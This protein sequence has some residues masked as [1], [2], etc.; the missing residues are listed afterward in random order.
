MA[1]DGKSRTDRDRTPQGGR[2]RR[3]RRL[4]ASVMA[5]TAALLPLAAVAQTAAPA[6]GATGAP[7]ADAPKPGFQQIRIGY[8]VWSEKQLTLSLSQTPPD[9]LG[10]AG[11]RSGIKDNNTTGTFTKQQFSLVTREA[12]DTEAALAALKALHDEGV[13]FIVTDAPADTLLAMADS[14]AGK[15]AVIFNVEAKDERLREEDCRASFV[16]V[17]PSHSMLADGLAQFLVWKKWP[18]WFLLTGALPRDELFADALKRAATRFGGEI[19]EERRFSETDTARRTDSGHV[20]IVQQMAV[21][22][23]NAPD[24]D[25]AMVADE[26]EIFGNYVPFRTWDPRPVA[27]SG[28]LIPTVWTPNHEQWAGYQMQTRFNALHNRQMFARDATAW[29][30]VRMVGD[31]ATK[32]QSDDSQKIRDALFADDFS[33]AAFKGQKLTIRKWNHQLRQPI[34]LTDGYTVVSVS[35]Q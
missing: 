16:H 33:V 13:R 12:G 34:L 4:A 8:V 29:T 2:S 1:D 26:S 15:T 21:F 24:Y 19:V 31:A 25:I 27:G 10:I 9:D 18:R 32:A 3:R 6:A 14:E 35:P 30:A 22:T 11:A 5:M 20:Q 23:Q 7:A 28:G 17:Q